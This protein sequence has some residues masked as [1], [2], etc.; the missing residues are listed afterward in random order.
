TNDTVIVLANGMSGVAP[1]PADFQAALSY[2]CAELAKLIVRDA[3]GASKFI[4]LTV[5]GARTEAEAHQVASTI[6]TSP[7]VKTAIYGRDA[8]WGRVLAAAGRSGVAIEPAKIG[9]HFGPLEVLRDGTPVPF[10]EDE[11]LKILS[12]SDIDIVLTLGQGEAATTMW[13][14][15]LT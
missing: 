14:C 2:V 4:T 12:E 3:E 6:A 11:A 8:N 13:T 1:A 10:S 7:L 9:L 15:D 5:K